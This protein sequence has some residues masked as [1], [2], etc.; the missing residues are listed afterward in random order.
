LHSL[1]SYQKPF[2]IGG[3]SNNIEYTI[4]PDQEVQLPGKF[5]KVSGEHVIIRVQ[6]KISFIENINIKDSKFFVKCF[7]ECRWLDPQYLR[8]VKEM[9]KAGTIRKEKKI[10]ITEDMKYWKPKIKMKN[11]S[12]ALMA[13]NYGQIDSWTACPKTGEMTLRVAYHGFCKCVL[14]LRKFPFDHHNMAVSLHF[15]N[16]DRKIWLVENPRTTTGKFHLRSSEWTL[17]EKN[18]SP[19][20]VERGWS[21][22]SESTSGNRY[23]GVQAMV[24]IEREYS[25]YLYN[26]VLM[27]VL[28]SS[29]TI[30][31]CCL[32]PEDLGN[33][34]QTVLTIMLTLVAF[35]MAMADTTPAIPYLTLMD[36]FLISQMG[37]IYAMF[38]ENCVVARF[39]VPH[40][41]VETVQ[42]ID[43][44]LSAIW[45]IAYLSVLGVFG[46]IGYAA[47]MKPNL[48][49]V[50]GNQYLDHPQRLDLR[51]PHSYRHG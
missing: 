30:G 2:K 44:I 39:L 42:Y 13:H 28:L 45:I 50:R 17:V 35:K 26:L 9:Q 27:V 48:A 8:D 22:P 12:K 11:T 6:I 46:Y 43:D 7:I 24:T 3:S 38:L 29:M 36:K 25:Y 14:N 19:V 20:L 31:A 37:I 10:K 32:T 47:T 41:D 1:L 16:K 21:D 49:E 23:P 4:V 15:M 18:G 33:R 51:V 34:S 5:G 40:Y